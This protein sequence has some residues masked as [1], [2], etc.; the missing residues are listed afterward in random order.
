MNIDYI[1]DYVLSG[2]MQ[3]MGFDPADENGL[4]CVATLSAKEIFDRYLRW[5]GIIGYSSVIWEAV[6]GLQLA[7][8]VVE[9]I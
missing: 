8:S 3:N 9:K 1:P 5:E 2:C 7:D 6:E 4:R